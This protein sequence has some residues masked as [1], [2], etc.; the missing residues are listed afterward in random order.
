MILHMGRTLT[1]CRLMQSGLQKKRA[2][3][4]SEKERGSEMWTRFD[5]ESETNAGAAEVEAAEEA[6]D[7][8]MSGAQVIPGH[9][10]GEETRRA[11]LR[12]QDAMWIPTFRLEEAIEERVREAGPV[13]GQFRA[14][15]QGRPRDRGL[16]CHIAKKLLAP[17]GQDLGLVPGRPRSSGRD[18][19]AVP[20]RPSGVALRR[21]GGGLFHAV[22]IV[23]DLTRVLRR[24]AHDRLEDVE[25][26]R[27][28]LRAA[29]VH[30][31]PANV[32]IIEGDHIR[33]LCQGHRR[34]KGC[35]GAR[36]ETV[37]P[38][39]LPPLIQMFT[40]EINVLISSRIAPPE[41]TAG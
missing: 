34:G 11:V 38:E 36:A 25:G 37:D 7:R 10:P 35:G 15:Y 30:H 39:D 26:R 28:T 1:D 19:P 41:T 18:C 6:V 24:H 22:K 33:G 12:H 29:E 27:P 9:L 2:F 32:V 13:P 5:N 21:R 17:P 40:E 4:K 20:F 14:Q 31:C 23:H 3:A 16:P 8:F